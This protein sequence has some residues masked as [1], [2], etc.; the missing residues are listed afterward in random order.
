VSTVE[1]RV[2]V[3]GDR[4]LMLIHQLPAKPAYLTL[5][6]ELLSGTISCVF[7]VACSIRGTARTVD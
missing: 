4:W 2:S 3:S 5:M 7:P 1:Q 6:Q